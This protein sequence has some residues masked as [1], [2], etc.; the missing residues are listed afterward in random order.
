MLTTIRDDVWIIYDAQHTKRAL[1]QFTDNAG[2]DL[3]CS[4]T[5]SMDTVVF[6]DEQRMP[7]SDCMFV[8]A[9][10][11]FCPHIHVLDGDHIWVTLSENAP[12]GVHPAKAQSRQPVGKIFSLTEKALCLCLAIEL[13][14]I[15]SLSPVRGRFQL[16]DYMTLHCTE[17]FIITRSSSRYDLNT[18][19]RDVKHQIINIIKLCECAVWSKSS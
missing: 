13:H 15:Q 6:V 11:G 5:E 19:E 1:M 7:R 4:L 9:E 18:V 16:Y 10:L 14:K 3:G 12:P 17:P 2:P 8:H